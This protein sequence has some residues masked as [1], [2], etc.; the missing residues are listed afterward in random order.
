MPYI[1][2]EEY[3]QAEEE[4]IRAGRARKAT[5]SKCRY[6]EQLCSKCKHLKS[7]KDD[8]AYLAARGF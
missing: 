8:G 7:C 3:K 6:D 2:R 5:K 4:R 1:D